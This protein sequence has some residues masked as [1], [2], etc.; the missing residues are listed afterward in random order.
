MFASFMRKY[1]LLSSLIF[2]TINTVCAQWGSFQRKMENRDSVAGFFGR[3]KIF[4]HH[5]KPQYQINDTIWLKGYVVSGVMNRVNDSSRIAYIEFIDANGSLVKRISALCDLGFFYSNI[6]LGEQLFPQGSYTLRAYTERMRSF[7][8]SLFFQTVIKVINPKAELWKATLNEWSFADNKLFIAAGLRGEGQAPLTSSRVTVALKSKNKTLFRRRMITDAGG[9]IYIDTLLKN[10]GSNKNFHLEISNKDL[11]LKI[12]LPGNDKNTDLQFLPEGGSLIA[13]YPQQLGF[14]AVNIYGKGV[15]VKG[16]IKDGRGNGIVPF[17]SVYNGMGVVA[18]TPVRGETYTAW[19]DD[20]SAYKIPPVDAAGWALQVR[21]NDG[22]DSIIIR[23]DTNDPSDTAGCF[24]TGNTRGYNFLKGRLRNKQH[25]ELALAADIFP[26]GVARFTLY[27]ANGIPVNE[28]AL[29]VWHGDDLK[30]QLSSAEEAY[31][32]KDSVALSLTAKDELTDP[33]FGSFSVAVLDTSQ[34]LL[35]LDAENL[36]SYMT[37]SADLKGAVETPYYFIKHPRSKATEALMLTQGWVRYD[38]GDSTGKYGYEKEFGI[39]GKVTNIL[40]KPSLNTNV[41]LFGRDGRN[42]VFFKD[43]LT[44]KDG[45][46]YFRD[47]P[48]F[49]TDSVSTLIKAVNKREKSFG[50]GVEVFNKEYP[51]LQEPETIFDAASILFDTA[52]KKAIDRRS[53]VMEQLRRDGRYLEEVIVTARARVPGSKNL[54]EDGGADQTITQSVLEQTPKDDLLT[55]LAKQIPGFPRMRGVPFA[56]GRSRIEIVIDGMD[57]KFF[58]MNPIDVLQYY[59][60]EDVKGIEIMRSPRYSMSYQVRFNE[61]KVDFMD[62]PIYVEITTYGG[63]GP[64]LKKMP[65]MYLLK[66]NAPSVGRLFY[67]PKY[68]SPEE[69]TV[70]PDLRQTIYWNPD[71][72]TNKNGEAYMSFYTSESKGSYLIIVQGTDLKGG[73]GTLI[74]P[75]QVQKNE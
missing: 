46:F 73:F 62:P 21:Y 75:L 30:L 57:L 37:L 70:F 60:A 29:F 13:G 65:G 11:D 50:I 55:V 19:L 15:A 44:N 28:R 9:N 10:Q 33:V 31:L 51:R 8:D 52:A 32:N 27:N 42:G 34:V 69:E 66:P 40:N 56:I 63:V 12:P 36:L 61:G 7:G 5:D 39:R 4:V 3:E 72:I 1:L 53:A 45:E 25:H 16:V 6:T 41:T 48:L 64:F 35:D 18:L 68:A 43:T 26:S 14:K 54:N 38:F 49:V 47:F 71:V 20:G 24:I 58:E 22:G 17:E 2:L 59:S 74:A 67:S 23:L